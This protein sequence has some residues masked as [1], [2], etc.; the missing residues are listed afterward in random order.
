[1]VV[2]ATMYRVWWDRSRIEKVMTA[3]V[4]WM[5]SKSQQTVRSLYL[6]ALEVNAS[7]HD[8]DIKADTSERTSSPLG[9]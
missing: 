6:N 3:A 4:Q 9:M 5:L 2:H 8:A 1:M 7:G